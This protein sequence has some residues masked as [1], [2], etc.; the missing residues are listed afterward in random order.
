MNPAPHAC[1]TSTLTTEASLQAQLPS[2]HLAFEMGYLT[3]SDHWIGQAG[4]LPTRF[5]NP[6]THNSPVLG[7]QVHDTI[8]SCF[9]F[10]IGSRGWNSGSHDCK[11]SINRAFT[12]NTWEPRTPQFPKDYSNN[13]TETGLGCFSVA[14][15]QYCKQGNL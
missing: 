7:S 8:L 13:R 3:D 2:P 4:C 9:F 14:V 15:L 10:F 5:R 1:M 6:F 11:H 12:P